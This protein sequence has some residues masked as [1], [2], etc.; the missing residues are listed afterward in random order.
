MTKYGRNLILACNLKC[1][2]LAG[3]VA[4]WV[5]S[6]CLFTFQ[7]TWKKSHAINFKTH[8]IQFFQRHHKSFKQCHKVSTQCS[9]TY[10]WKDI[11]KQTM[12]ISNDETLFKHFFV[13]YKYYLNN[14][15][16]WLFPSLLVLNSYFL[17]AVELLE[18][19]K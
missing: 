12:T 17:S 10:V 11:L 6:S 14:I 16:S 13:I 4:V 7:W 18:F 8:E 2:L 19:L 5:Y 1:T 15:P 9:N 3:P